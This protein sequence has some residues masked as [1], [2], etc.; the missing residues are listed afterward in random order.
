MAQLAYILSGAAPVMKKF[1]YGVT[2]TA[3]GIPFTIPAAGTAGVVIGTT[4][5][6]TDLVGLSLDQG[7]D[8]L[9]GAQSTYTTTQGTGAS[10]AER[11]VTL[12]INPDAAWRFL[13]SGGATDN[14]TL[15]TQT[16]TTAQADGTAVTTGAS[17][18]SS[19]EYD[20]GYV[21]GL[22]GANAGAARKITSTSSTAGTVTIP[23]D[24]PIAVGD[25]FLR[26]PYTPMQGATIQLTT[27]LTQANAI[28]SVATGAPFRPIELIL[29]DASDSGA[30]NSYVVAISNS[31]AL[32]LA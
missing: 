12:I 5:G 7:L 18:T 1:Q 22:T 16:V 20:E 6:A 30:T 3:V 19:V 24:Y 26:C 10:S 23:F 13:M 17:W 21:W 29:R 14:T 2:L 4:T 32:N 11:M 27:A 8:K 25:T 28:I 15:A 31:H 9:G